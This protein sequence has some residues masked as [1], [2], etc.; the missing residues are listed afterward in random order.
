MNAM[1]MIIMGKYEFYIFLLEC[2]QGKLFTNL[3]YTYFLNPSL[4]SVL[5]YY[6][7]DIYDDVKGTVLLRF[8]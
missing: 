8:M 1:L 5:N 3:K 7:L 6:L 2:F 4:V